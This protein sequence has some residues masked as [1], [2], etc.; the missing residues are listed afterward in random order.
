MLDSVIRTLQIIES[1]HNARRGLTIQEL[2]GILN[3]NRTT[4]HHQ[5]STLVKMG[6]LFQDSVTRKYDI[7]SHL[8]E[9]GQR[10]LNRLDIRRVAHFHLER[11]SRQL[12]ETVNLLILR[13][14]ELVYIDK[15]DLSQRVGDLKPSFYIGT[16]TQAYAT[17]AGKVLLAS[18]SE[19]EIHDMLSHNDLVARTEHTITDPAVLR[20][21]LRTISR[22]GF[23]LDNEEHQIGIKCVAVPIKNNRV[24]VVAA[25][26]VSGPAGRFKASYMTESILPELRKTADTI[27]RAFGY[28]EHYD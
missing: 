17:A 28:S 12:D 22:Q 26:S 1:I 21:E 10:Y 9:I 16:S 15:I 24:Q 7:G 20:K 25:V 2:A 19:E 23:A 13:N 4:L 27:S 8:I 6:Y 3:K 18:L 11:L 5:V 14:F